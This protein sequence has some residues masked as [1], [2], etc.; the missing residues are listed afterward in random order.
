MA[1]SRPSRFPRV[2]YAAIRHH[3]GN[4]HVSTPD[5]EVEANMSRRALEAKATPAEH[6]ELVRYALAVHREN[7]QLFRRV[8]SGR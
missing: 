2:P 5:A 7:R 4:V 6:R 8:M 1:T 3:L